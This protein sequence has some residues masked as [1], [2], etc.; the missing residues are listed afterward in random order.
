M[1]FLQVKNVG[2]SYGQ[3]KVLKDISI[4]IEKGEF[5]CLLGPSGCGKSTLL[6]IIAGL[7][8]KHGGKIIIN[9]K[10]MTNSPPE[11]RNFGIVFQSYAL[12]PNMNVYKNIAFGL[13]N[14]NISKSN[15]DKKV[16]EVLDV[17]ELSG[18]EKKYPSQLSGGQQQRVALARAIALEP[19]FLLLDEPLSALDAKV[20]LKLR[21]QIRSLHRKLG[22]T[23]IMVTHDQE[24][25]LCLADKMVVMNRGEI[26]QVGTPK[27]VYKNPET[28]F[29]ADFIGTIDFMDDDINMIAIRPEDI[30]VEFNRDFKEVDIKVREILDI[31]FRRFNYIVTV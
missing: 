9:D 11:S 31:E 29:V 3:V 20:R 21:E 5:I 15:I 14:K 10:D 12:F 24:E 27:E 19:D 25:A 30:K 16:K 26:I 13:E 22:I 23:T 17:V 7:E 8:D 2:K 18:Y 6:R 4:D 1:S 28:P